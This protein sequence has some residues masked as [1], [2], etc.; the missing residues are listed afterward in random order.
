[1][2]EQVFDRHGEIMIGIE[3]TTGAGHD[4]MP[5]MVGIAGEG[6]IEAVLAFDQPGHGVG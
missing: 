3:Q 4:A 6:H 1:M 2:S 5:V